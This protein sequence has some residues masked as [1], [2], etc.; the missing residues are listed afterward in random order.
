MLFEQSEK[1]FRLLT[2]PYSKKR[3]LKV[4][5][6]SQ[7]AVFALAK[8]GAGAKPILRTCPSGLTVFQRKTMVFSRRGRTDC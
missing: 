5:K 1:S 6:N 4:H 2:N 7:T 3:Y 8:R